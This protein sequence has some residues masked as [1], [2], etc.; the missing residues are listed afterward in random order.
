MPLTLFQVDAFA[1]RPFHGN[2]AAVVP[3]TQWLADSLLQ[4]IAEENN[5]AETAFFVPTP[6]DEDADYHL[7]WFTPVAE[8]DLCGHATLASASVLFDQ[9]GFLEPELRFRTR[10]GVLTVSRTPQGLRMLLPAAAP[11][12]CA[13]PATLAGALGVTPLE[14]L[15][16]YDLIAVLE[17]EDQVRTLEPNLSLVAQ[18][19]YRGVIVTAP[20][21]PASGSDFVSRFFAPR[22]GVPEDPVTGS[23]HCELVPFW[24]GRLG[25]TVLSARQLSRR[26]GT[27]ACELLGPQVALTGNAALYLR[28]E[29]PSLDVAPA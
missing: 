21:L 18:M 26:G 13:A 23:A 17:S 9:L 4:A 6:Q 14:T 28:G 10:S 19:P 2:P 3:L 12:P 20:A 16:A 7:R 27:L 1:D 25:R 11:A 29:L 15:A 5:L 8:V 22:L 24:A